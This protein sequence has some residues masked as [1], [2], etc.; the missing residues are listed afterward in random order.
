[1][2]KEAGFLVSPENMAFQRNGAFY[3]WISPVRLVDL[4]ACACFPFAYFLCNFF[5]GTEMP[6]FL[7]TPMDLTIRTGAMARLECAA[8]GH[9]APQISWQKDGGTDFPAARERRMHV[10][11]E[12][13]VFFIANVKIEDMGIYSCMAQN[14]AGGLSANASLIVLGTLTG[15]G[16]LFSWSLGE[17]LR[18]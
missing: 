6:S 10:M 4:S 11:P 7:K 1:M 16:P 5:F 12:D 2:L 8:E 17:L 9:P 15:L 18:P 13:D 3:I 14:I